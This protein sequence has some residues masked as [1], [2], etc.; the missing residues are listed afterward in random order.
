MKLYQREYCHNCG[1]FVVF[2]FGDTA[3]RQIIYC[4]SCGHEH[5]REIDEG[6]LTN[7]RLNQTNARTVRFAKVPPL[8]IQAMRS[9]DTVTIPD[10][11]IEER[12]VLGVTPDNE[13]IL[14]TKEGEI[15][16]RKVVSDRRW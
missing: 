11:E 15:P 16:N 8:N 1:G 6:T 4:P 12:K 10:I 5:Y 13:V 14:E 3:R 2:E 7:I 9:T